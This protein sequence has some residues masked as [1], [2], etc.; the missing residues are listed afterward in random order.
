MRVDPSGRFV[1]A[2]VS[3]CLLPA[4][5]P[6]GLRRRVAVHGR[7]ASVEWTVTNTGSAE[8]SLGA[9]GAAMPFN[10]MFT[11]RTLSAVSGKCSFTDPYIGGGGGYVQVTRAS[12]EGPVLLVLLT[13]TLTLTPTPNAIP[14]PNA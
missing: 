13:L 2:D 5:G 11:G 8:L 4:G 7:E 6:L 14:D 10:Q 1:E 3:G 9:F 12:G